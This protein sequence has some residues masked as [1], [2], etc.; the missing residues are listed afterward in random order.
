[1]SERFEKCVCGELKL[2]RCEQHEV[3]ICELKEC[4]KVGCR[5][6]EEEAEEQEDLTIFQNK[7][8]PYE[9]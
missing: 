2:A 5:R 9:W 4:E 8:R 6:C 1:M 7:Q 3:N